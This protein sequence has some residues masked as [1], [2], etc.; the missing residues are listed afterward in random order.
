[1]PEFSVEAIKQQALKEIEEFE[2]R[3]AVE[4]EKVR[5]LTYRSLWVRLFPWKIVII[6]RS[7]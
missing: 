6:K 5:I 4:A 3:S 2:F 7:N 1:M